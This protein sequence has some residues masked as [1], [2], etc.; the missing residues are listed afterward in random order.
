MTCQPSTWCSKHYF[1]FFIISYTLR[2]WKLFIHIV[3]ILL[4][5]KKINWNKRFARNY[6]KIDNTWNIRHLSQRPSEPAYLFVHCCIL[7]G[8]KHK[9]LATE[10]LLT[11]WFLFNADFST[12]ETIAQIV[13]CG[14][15]SILQL[16]YQFLVSSSSVLEWWFYLSH[17][18]AMQNCKIPY[19]L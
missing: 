6:E 18:S 9:L 5:N 10:C 11:T 13:Q 14:W 17:H 7:I 2:A 16:M 19:R 3:V 15:F 8:C 4:K 12:N 1:F